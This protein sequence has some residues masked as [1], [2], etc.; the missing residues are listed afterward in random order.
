MPE[1]SHVGRRWFQ[2]RLSAI[3]VV[4]V[5]VGLCVAH[6]RATRLV[7][8]LERRN[9][10]LESANSKLRVEAGYLEIDDPSKAVVLRI[11]NLEEDTW[12]WKVWLP[13]G[14]WFLSCLTEGIPRQGVTNGSSS[15]PIDGDRELP[16]YVTLRKGPDGQWIFRF[17]VDETSIGSVVDASN[18]LVKQVEGA[19]IT[20]PRSTNIAGDKSQDVLDPGQPVVLL[21]LRAFEVVATPNGSWEGQDNG[22]TS[23]GIMVWLYRAK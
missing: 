6:F 20:R 5:I 2:F 12:Q 19:S 1:T 15:G 18:W 17:G 13:P 14:R 9:R 16:V 22:A 21:R 8:K 3:L 4:I 7:L 23:D 10:E 11:Q